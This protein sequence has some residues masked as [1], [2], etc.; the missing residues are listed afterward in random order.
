MLKVWHS[1]LRSEVQV[2]LWIVENALNV[3]V[4]STNYCDHVF[5]DKQEAR[6]V[7]RDVCKRV[8]LELQVDTELCKSTY[9]DNSTSQ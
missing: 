1:R 6:A 5:K 7:V 8:C 2:S 4:I 9:S 3:S